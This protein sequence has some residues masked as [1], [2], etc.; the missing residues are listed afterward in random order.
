M[1][2][3]LN[4]LIDKTLGFAL[5]TRERHGRGQANIDLEAQSQLQFF[6]DSA[7]GLQAVFDFDDELVHLATLT[8]G[9]TELDDFG[10]AAEDLL[11]RTR[12]NVDATDDHH[13]ISSAKHTP[14]EQHKN[15]WGRR[16]AK[17]V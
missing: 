15:D 17:L 11:D 1:L 2:G 12:K 5:K 10:E 14:F 4:T 7:W 9:E 6:G 13:I 8:S 16:L 3:R